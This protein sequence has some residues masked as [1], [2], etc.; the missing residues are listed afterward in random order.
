MPPKRTSPAGYQHSRTLRQQQTPAEMKLW[1]YLRDR[2]LHG[3]TFRRQ[4]AIGPYV[5]DFC[6][7]RHHLVIEL[8]GSLHLQQEEEDTRRTEY[9][10]SRG[11]RVLRLWNDKVMNDMQAVAATILDALRLE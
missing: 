7:P 9:L 8:D 6:S 1:A 3:V 4:H 5:T 2:R 10:V 11:Y